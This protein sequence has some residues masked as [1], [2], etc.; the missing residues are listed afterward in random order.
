[1]FHRCLLQAE[2]QFSHRDYAHKEI[3]LPD[4]PSFELCRNPL[5]FQEREHVGI[6]QHAHLNLSSWRS[7]G[8]TDRGQRANCSN[9]SFPEAP[10]LLM[11]AGVSTMLFWPSRKGRTST[12]PPRDN[13]DASRHHFGNVPWPTV[14]RVIVSKFLNRLQG[15]LKG[16]MQSRTLAKPLRGFVSTKSTSLRSSSS[17]RPISA[18]QFSV[19]QVRGQRSEIGGQ[20]SEV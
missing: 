6:E 1:M 16:E 14:E 18:F 12:T 19:I 3:T 13:P 8:S 4:H 15:F 7:G 20:K 2:L 17:R 11:G 5:L 10:R 9:N